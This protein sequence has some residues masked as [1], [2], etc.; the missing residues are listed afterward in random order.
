MSSDSAVYQLSS[1]QEMDGHEFVRKEIVY[2]LDVNN[3]SYSSNQ[4]QFDTSSISN[5]GKWA[6][7][8]EAYFI[9]PYSI[10]MT[11]GAT[12]ISGANVVSPFMCTLKNG[13]WQIIDSMQVD[14]N[15]VNIV[16]QTNFLNAHATFK[17][18]STW[19]VNDQ[20]KYGPSCG[21]FKDSA[22][23]VAYSV[24]AAPATV[25][26]DGV[27][28]NRVFN[29]GSTV[30][31]TSVFTGTAF[32]EGYFERLLYTSNSAAAGLNGV[33]AFYTAYSTVGMPF[34]SFSGAADATR[35][36]YW[37]F[38]AKIRLADICDYFAKVP[39]LKGSFYRITLNANTSIS[40]ITGDGGAGNM[41]LTSA[42]VT[43]RTNPLLF[44]SAAADQPSR[45]T[46]ALNP[47]LTVSTGI[48]SSLS[49][50]TSILSGTRLYVPIY[51]MNPTYEEQYVSMNRTKSIVYDDLY[52]FYISNIPIG[53]FQQL[54]SNGITNPKYVL[55]IPLLNRAAG[56][57]CIIAASE[58]ESPFSSC[59][60]TTMPLGVIQN[61]QVQ[62]SGVNLFSQQQQ[63]DFDQFMSELSKTGLNGG[64]TSGLSSGL[65]SERD[66]QYAFRYYLADLSRRL[67]SED[68]YPKSIQVQGTNGTT[69]ILDLLTFV[70]YQRAIIVDCVTGSIVSE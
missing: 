63:Y 24:A 52:S 54:L 16:Q 60:G 22:T 12:N 4:I 11:S 56:N 51:T 42:T 30:A 39:L 35:V 41:T 44:A 57:N 18:L 38:L 17:A 47:T 70:A 1:S 48:G 55:V 45:A 58:L 31:A 13:F 64:Q 32:N 25:N 15:G 21:F 61:F 34:F 40:V 19:S 6:S 68:I 5:S 50:V 36:F 37:S 69:K 9:I 59:P 3:Q 28:N 29:V 33:G 62:L 10:K 67:P 2:I 66:F 65:I 7:F 8:S 27:S 49:G 43:G 46:L 14:L 26:G 20:M 53:Q 23:S